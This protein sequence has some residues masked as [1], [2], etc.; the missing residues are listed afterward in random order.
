MFAQ[1]SCFHERTTEDCAELFSVS[2]SSQMSP[3]FSTKQLTIVAT[4]WD[5]SEAT[6]HSRWCPGRPAEITMF[7]T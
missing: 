4:A 7:L 6:G 3:E 1:S 5:Q 2:G